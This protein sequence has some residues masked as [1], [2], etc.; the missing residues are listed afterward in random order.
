MLCIVRGIDEDF[1]QQRLITAFAQC[2]VDG[3][4]RD[5]GIMDFRA[6]SINVRDGS[7][8]RLLFRVASAEPLFKPSPKP[9][10]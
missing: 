10:R 8:E 7:S 4:W 9:Q 1:F 2:D 5:P 3:I 6:G